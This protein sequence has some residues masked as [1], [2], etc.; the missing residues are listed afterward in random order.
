MAP[1]KVVLRFASRSDDT[2]YVDWSS[3]VSELVT[4]LRAMHS[5]LRDSRIRLFHSGISLDPQQTWQ[6]FRA[7]LMVTKTQDRRPQPS[8]PTLSTNGEESET[9]NTAGEPQIDTVYIHC[10]VA[11]LPSLASLDEQTSS[12]VSGEDSQSDSSDQRPRPPTQGFERLQQ[13]AGL[14]GED[15]ATFRRQFHALRGTAPNASAEQRAQME[16]EW[17]DGTGGQAAHDQDHARVELT[18][19][20]AFQELVV[21]MAAGFFLGIVVILWLPEKGIFQ[22]RQ[23]LA[24]ACGLFINVVLGML[25]VYT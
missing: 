10:A 17:L 18:E 7:K 20:A 14:N 1:L 22:P 11:A 2:L 3:G 21:G 24:V 8:S 25:F 15:V 6:A 12:L 16:E 4:Q 5:D 19:N 13:S 23:Q 9:A